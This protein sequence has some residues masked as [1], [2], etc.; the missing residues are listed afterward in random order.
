MCAENTCNN[1]VF[2]ATFSTTTFRGFICIEQ[3]D[4]QC[5]ICEVADVNTLNYLLCAMCV[6]C[7]MEGTFLVDIILNSIRMESTCPQP[8]SY[9]PKC[10]YLH[11][12]YVF[13]TIRQASFRS[14][15]FQGTRLHRHI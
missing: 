4:L 10:V 12:S 2:V 14:H 8:K 6:L 3:L 7:A 11:V 1:L 13:D 5:V 15:L 9:L